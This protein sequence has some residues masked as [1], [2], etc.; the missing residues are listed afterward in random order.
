MNQNESNQSKSSIQENKSRYLYQYIHMYVY[1]F[2]NRKWGH[3]HININIRHQ[4]STILSISCLWL[5]VV[6]LRPSVHGPLFSHQGAASHKASAYWTACNVEMVLIQK[7]WKAWVFHGFG[8]EIHRNLH[9]F[10]ASRVLPVPWLHGS[11][12]EPPKTHLRQRNGSPQAWEGTLNRIQ[13]VLKIFC[14]T[15]AD[16][17]NKAWTK[18]NERERSW[19]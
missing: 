12:R 8:E 7:R 3:V 14:F 19:K 4:Q 5:Y 10:V 11:T 16:F 13:A 17:A 15:F 6:G 9:G 1:G 2:S 18:E